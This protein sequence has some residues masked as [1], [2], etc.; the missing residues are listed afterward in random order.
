MNQLP[1]DEGDPP[2]LNAVQVADQLS[3]PAGAVRLWLRH[4]LLGSDNRPPIRPLVARLH[5]DQVE[6]ARVVATLLAAGFTT[7]ALTRYSAAV[8][9][10]L[11]DAVRRVLEPRLEDLIDPAKASSRADARMTP[12]RE[13]QRPKVDR[14]FGAWLR[15]AQ[16]DE[17]G[18]CGD[19]YP[20]TDSQDR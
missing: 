1:T 9:A 16:H 17:Q 8:R 4:G 20:P 3:V 15:H 13:E 10:E 2:L 14:L 7:T 11:A 6:S 12:G 18:G 19:D 5:P